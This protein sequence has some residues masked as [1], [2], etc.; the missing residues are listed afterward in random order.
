MSCV[1]RKGGIGVS[2]DEEVLE[3]IALVLD[4]IKFHESEFSDVKVPRKAAMGHVLHVIRQQLRLSKEASFV[5]IDLGEA[6]RNSAT[7]DEVEM[8]I[9]GTLFQETHVWNSCL[10]AL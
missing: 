9:N 8:L 2:D 3:Q 1:L 7:R 4:V 10:Q 6:I 5:L